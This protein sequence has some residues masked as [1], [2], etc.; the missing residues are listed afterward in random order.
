LEALTIID[1]APDG[2]GIAAWKGR[3]VLLSNTIPGEVVNAESLGEHDNG[4]VAQ[5]TEFIETSADRVEPRDA[6]CAPGYSWQHIDYSAQ[7]A[8]KADIVATALE[9]DAKIKKPPVELTVPSP[10]QWHYARRLTLHLNTDG[11]L[12]IPEREGVRSIE[13][14][15]TV[16]DEIMQLVGEVNL[17]LDTVTKIDFHANEDGDRMLVLQTDD[18]E[19]PEL[20]VTLP[21]SVNFL[22]NHFEPYN[23]I[24]STHITHRVL[25]R[26]LRMTAG[27]QTRANIGALEAIVESI[28]G[29]L[30]P[31]PADSVLDVFGGVGTF[32]V[33]LADLVSYITYIDSYPPAATDA[34]FNLAAF[35]NVDIVEGR[36]GNILDEIAAEDDRENYAVA[37][38]D[39]PPTG[40][41][42][43][44]LKA[45]KKLS[46]PRLMYIASDIENMVR[47]VNF[48]S[49]Q[50]NYR[51]RS[52]Q[53]IDTAPQTPHVE[54]VILLERR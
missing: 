17:A 6:G 37:I 54:S 13:S 2:R 8:L 30:Q 21:A 4:I 23:L 52:V 28:V 36:A 40:L 41:H 9:Y 35:D 25:D 31:Q 1:I 33:G 7:L 43:D 26:T 49:H 27:V 38:L 19:A 46:L 50:M 48:I 29:I 42:R 53:P 18:D 22:L 45:L 24:G 16:V 3:R 44:V 32:S 11:T 39:P 34:E 10:Q 5:V 51:V 12:G 15:A 47:D 14:C 20:E